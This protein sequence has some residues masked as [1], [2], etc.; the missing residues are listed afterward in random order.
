MLSLILFCI[1]SFNRQALSAK[2]RHW[3]DIVFPIMQH[4]DCNAPLADMLSPFNNTSMLI[5]DAPR[6]RMWRQSA[7]AQSSLGRT[8][9]H[10]RVALASCDSYCDSYSSCVIRYFVY[11][12]IVNFLLCLFSVNLDISF[13]LCW[14]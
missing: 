7:H 6:C 1:Q 13:V 14:Y 8:E 4:S 11:V 2:G 9:E 5:S 12:I 3:R 10:V